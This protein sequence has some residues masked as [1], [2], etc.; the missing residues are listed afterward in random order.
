M[1]ALAVGAGGLVEFPFQRRS[2]DSDAAAE[3]KAG[4]LVTPASHIGR[5]VTGVVF[6]ADKG[7]CDELTAPFSLASIS[8]ADKLAEQGYKVLLVSTDQ[9][10]EVQDDSDV[11]YQMDLVEQAVAFLKHKQDI[12]RVALF[13]VGRGGDLAIKM[14]MERPALLDCAIVMCP[15]GEIAWTPPPK[16]VEEPPRTLPI[17]LLMG[18]KHA[19]SQSDAVRPSAAAAMCLAS[20]ERLTDFMLDMFH[21]SNA[22]GTPVRAKEN[23]RRRS[24]C[25]RA[26][27]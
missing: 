27:S 14:A 9:E 17:L 5:V 19:Y 7:H 23:A 22:C 8:Y 15:D 20:H 21:S 3:L 4:Y 13:G 24:R 18:D 2:A 1:R 10:E 26:C 12:Q 6:V 16:T 25:A 11:G